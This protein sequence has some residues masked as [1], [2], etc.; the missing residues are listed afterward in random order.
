MREGCGSFVDRFR[1][2]DF[3]LL[4]VSLFSLLFSS[5]SF[6]PVCL[7][8]LFFRKEEGVSEMNMFCSKEARNN[9]TVDRVLDSERILVRMKSICRV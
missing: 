7:L 8:D 9:W 4:F 5:S 6:S 2:W 3:L 1:A